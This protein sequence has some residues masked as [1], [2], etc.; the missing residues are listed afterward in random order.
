MGFSTC[1]SCRKWICS[2]AGWTLADLWNEV[3]QLQHSWNLWGQIPASTK[4]YFRCVSILCLCLGWGWSL[5][6]G[7]LC[8]TVLGKAL[9]AN[10]E[11]RKCLFFISNANNS[12]V[13]CVSVFLALP[14]K[15]L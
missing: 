2:R 6:K 11:G 9:E 10:G 15:L 14:Q 5:P 7:F 8:P 1:K 3:M 4:G 13:K 12:L